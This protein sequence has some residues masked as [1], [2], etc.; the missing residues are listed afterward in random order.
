MSSAIEALPGDVLALIL[1][2]CGGS[3]L[4]LMLVCKTFLRVGFAKLFRPSWRLVVAL[5]AQDDALQKYRQWTQRLGG[6]RLRVPYAVLRLRIP[7]G[8]EAFVRFVLQECVFLGDAGDDR[9]RELELGHCLEVACRF[10]HVGIARLL[11]ACG[12]SPASNTG[13]SLEW[14]A[15]WGHAAAVELLL[16]NERFVAHESFGLFCAVALRSAKAAGHAAV[17]KMIEER[18]RVGE[19]DL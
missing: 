14:A 1:R 3:P 5:A 18:G 13:L 6:Y 15:M 4:S 12:A 16:S 2:H 8:D 10:G 9:T 11:L 17:C 7:K 19:L